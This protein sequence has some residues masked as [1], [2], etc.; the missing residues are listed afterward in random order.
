MSDQQQSDN[1][2]GGPANAPNR[3]SFNVWDVVVLVFVCLLGVCLFW[4]H[5]KGSHLFFDNVAF[6]WTAIATIFVFILIGWRITYLRLKYGFVVD[7]RSF[8][9]S[10]RQNW[11]GRQTVGW[12]RR[13]DDE[14][15]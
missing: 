9:F 5:A 6:Q 4:L 11:F 10:M 7:S 15:K 14:P 1:P 12:R 8:V 13:S 2:D 3:P